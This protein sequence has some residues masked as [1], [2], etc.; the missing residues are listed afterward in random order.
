MKKSITY[1]GTLLLLVSFA[2]CDFNSNKNLQ[3]EMPVYKEGDAIAL[4]VPTKQEANKKISADFIFDVGPRF[5]S[6]K[7]SDI[8]SATAFRDFIAEEHA[9]R[10]V[11]YTNVSVILLD[12]D[13]KTDIKETGTEGDFNEAQLKM[14]RAADYTTN[15]LI[16]A[17]YSEKSFETGTL[18]NSTWTP[19][20][21][22]VP[23]KQAAYAGGKDV[24]K[25]LLEKATEED[26]KNVDPEKL[27]PAELFFTV[28]KNG[29]IKNVHLNRTSGYPAVDEKMIELIN[30]YPE[31]WTPAENVKGEKVDQV[32]VVS[33]GLRGC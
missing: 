5:N 25:K 28:T 6:I 33:F 29:T 15:L 4:N 13:Q 9:N 26:R 22:I 1:F 11:N 31:N 32:L 10:I 27:Q 24:L 8:A 21:S 20:I 12:G 7:K 18:Q 16:W 14:L 17:D 2:A 30:E 3:K 23:E 19:Y